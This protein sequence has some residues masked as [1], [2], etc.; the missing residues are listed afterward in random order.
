VSV[1]HADQWPESK[2]T[3]VTLLLVA[4]HE[5]IDKYLDTANEIKVVSKRNKNEKTVLSSNMVRGRIR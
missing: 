2:Q 4:V 1:R 3:N 5:F